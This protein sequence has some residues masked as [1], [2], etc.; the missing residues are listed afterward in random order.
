M[1]LKDDSSNDWCEDDFDQDNDI[2]RPG[3]SG[4]KHNT[5]HF[6]VM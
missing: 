6:L 2:N 3:T 4:I 1:D 5:D